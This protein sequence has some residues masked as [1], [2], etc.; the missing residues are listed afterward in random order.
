MIKQHFYVVWLGPG[1][2]DG[3]QC[4]LFSGS[5]VLGTTVVH[6][7]LDYHEAGRHDFWALSTFYFF[8]VEIQSNAHVTF[9]FSK[10]GSLQWTIFNLLIHVLIFSI[11]FKV[12]AEWHRNQ[13]QIW[14]SLQPFWRQPQ[15]QPSEQRPRRW[16]VS[17][18]RLQLFRDHRQPR[19]QFNLCMW[20]YFIS[21]PLWANFCGFW[22]STENELR[23]KTDTPG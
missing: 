14:I 18:P 5:Q 10:S 3:L 20:V 19:G 13:S 16:N 21:V 9:F 23:Q 2:M 17:V 12:E 4:Y 22:A 6:C 15:N 11:F 8:P 7:C 1:K